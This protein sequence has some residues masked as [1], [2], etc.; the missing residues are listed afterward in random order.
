M[1]ELVETYHFHPE[2][3]E[4]IVGVEF[5]FSIPLDIIRKFVVE[6]KFGYHVVVYREK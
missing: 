6:T 5:G 2:V 4:D 3:N 1:G